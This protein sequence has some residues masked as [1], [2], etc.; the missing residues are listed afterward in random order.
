M[1]PSGSHNYS[2]F[3]GVFFPVNWKR[4]AYTSEGGPVRA[5]VQALQRVSA[6]DVRT[7]VIAVICDP[8]TGGVVSEKVPGKLEPGETWEIRLEM[9]SLDP[10]LKDN[11]RREK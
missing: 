3:L 2:S 9:E 7:S 5:V 1:P 8:E 11:P 6:G 4:K 10:N